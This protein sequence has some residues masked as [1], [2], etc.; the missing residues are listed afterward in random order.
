M[1]A[2]SVSSHGDKDAG[3]QGSC[4]ESL[5][6]EN[7][8]A[9]NPRLD[10]SQRDDGH[11]DGHH[12][13]GAAS[14]P[15]RTRL[16]W[17]S[18]T[19]A[20]QTCSLC[21]HPQPNIGRER[22]FPSVSE[23]SPI[24]ELAD[25]ATTT[26]ENLLSPTLYDCQ[27]ST[28]NCE[29]END[30]AAGGL[31]KGCSILT[32]RVSREL[33]RNKRLAKTRGYPS[34][35]RTTAESTSVLA[36]DT[37]R[38]HLGPLPRQP[39]C[40]LSS[41]DEAQE[42]FGR[43]ILRIQPHSPRNTYI[44]TFLQDIAQP[45][46]TPSTSEKPCEKPFNSSGRGP[47]NPAKAQ[48]VGH[49][50]ILIDPLILADD[51]PWE[52]GVLRQPF[53]LDDNP[54]PLETTCPYPDPPSISYNASGQRNSVAQKQDDDPRLASYPHNLV[55]R[56]LPHHRHSIAASILPSNNAPDHPHSGKQSKF[57]KRKPRHSDRQSPKRVRCSTTAIAEEN[58]F[59][60]LRSHFL[61]LPL[62]ER[63]QFLLWLLEG[64]LPRHMLRSD[65][66]TTGKGDVRLASRS[67]H[68]PSCGEAR[69]SS[70]KGM[71]WSSEEVDLLLRL[72]RD[73]NRPWSEVT[74]LFSD[75]FP[76]RSQG[77]IQVF[78]STTL[79]NRTH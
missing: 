61:S 75:Q 12:R 43:G 70:R 10:T 45:A 39:D 71:P 33:E 37:T 17:P 32:S 66:P 69:G 5:R 24:R 62:N 34:G 72:R 41:S 19:P 48:V 57:R 40:S 49:D 16:N 7:I 21:C 30:Q 38:E 18:K 29:C 77:S 46:S 20:G 1:Q 51:R 56:Q 26:T 63:V 54:N 65:L 6:L 78:W 31:M 73:E 60:A 68:S 9:E 15:E 53:L 55:H 47:E 42:V 36:D 4:V 3:D 50:D 22:Q 76:G 79:K 64:A 28:N 13:N 2:K 58:P 27:M 52:A 67:T 8:G 35:V 44:I 14:C 25:Q 23:Y 59:A 74:R 11:P